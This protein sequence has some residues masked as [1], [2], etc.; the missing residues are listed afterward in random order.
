MAAEFAEVLRRSPFVEYRD[1][2]MGVL[3]EEAWYVADDLRR[4]R[5][6]EELARL[7]DT[8]RRA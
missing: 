4:D 3:S 6:A 7:I 5:D 8:A 2:D 1:A